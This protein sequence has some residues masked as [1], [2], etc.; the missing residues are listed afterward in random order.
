MSKTV[1][2]AQHSSTIDQAVRLSLAGY[3][4]RYVVCK[5]SEQIVSA[6]RSNQPHLVI[7]DLRSGNDRML[8]VCNQLKSDTELQTIPLIVLQSQ[9]SEPLEA[10]D[11]QLEKPFR[12]E[13]LRE[14]V[15]TSFKSGE[16]RADDAAGRDSMIYHQIYDPDTGNM[17][18]ESIIPKELGGTFS[19]LS[20]IEADFN[21]TADAQSQ[22]PAATQ[23]NAEQYQR[24]TKAVEEQVSQI[25]SQWL[26]KY[27]EKEL[28]KV[29]VSSARDV[30]E[31]KID[32]SLP[33]LIQGVVRQ[34]LLSLKNKR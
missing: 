4:L 2:L 33:K 23:L 12:A 34:Q 31:S 27:A 29:I 22:E 25:I 10:A 11:H 6:C 28:R 13:Q 16:A 8:E 9:G 20:G 14:L 17:V 24:L 26:E 5:S 19:P 32:Q 30:I 1:L 15:E 3:G 18:D 21:P 7:C